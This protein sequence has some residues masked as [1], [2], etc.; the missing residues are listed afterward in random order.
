MLT[1]K[2]LHVDICLILQLMT[3]AHV[4]HLKSKTVV[5][6]MNYVTI[7]TLSEFPTSALQ[8]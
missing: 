5:K 4:F 1:M 3:L 2:K 8:I 7:C 6:Y